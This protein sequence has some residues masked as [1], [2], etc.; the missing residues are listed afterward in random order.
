V[1]VKQSIYQDPE[2]GL[3]VFTH[4]MMT[5]MR[6][7]PQQFA[8][9]YVERLKPR[10]VGA[11]L[12][13]GTWL[14]ALLEAHYKGESWEAV[15][16]AYSADYGTLFDE[17]QDALGDLPTECDRI[18]R[19]YLWHWREGPYGRESDPKWKTIETEM[20]LEVPLPDG[21]LYRCRIDVLAEDENGQLIVIDHKS[22]KTLPDLSYRIADSQSLLYLWALRKSGYD[23]H[24]FVWNYLRTK[25]PTKPQMIKDGSRLSAKAVETDYPTARRAVDEYGL[26]IKHPTI[27]R[28]LVALQRQRWQPGMIQTSPF[29]RREFVDRT[30]EDLE[31]MAMSALYTALRIT[32]YP[33]DEP[34]MVERVTSRDC[35]FR[36]SFTDL[37]STEIFGGNADNVR[38]LNF[39]V[40]DPLDYYEDLKDRR[41]IT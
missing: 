23:V 33:W 37:C 30:D 8:Y 10:R 17:E 4:S 26:S 16:D 7:C 3:E 36:C 11:P 40:G 38:R 34:D 2:S 6:R 22:H 27:N 29:F 25:A 31:R 13:R 28:W 5:T 14:H 35:K 19:S 20:K 18:M 15:H 1:T 21:R 32:E 24:R 12:R 41:E 39:T 9:K